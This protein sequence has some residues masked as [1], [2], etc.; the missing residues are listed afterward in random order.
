MRT[1]SPGPSFFGVFWKILSLSVLGLLALQ[2]CSVLSC[3]NRNAVTGKQ[4]DPTA[5]GT[6][7]E[8]SA[9]TAFSGGT[10]RIVVAFNDETNDGTFIT[11][12]STTRHMNVGASL[13][14]WS[15]SDDGGTT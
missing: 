4:G 10:T 14:G 8:T 13:M 5:S 1:C 2:A 15:Y 11:Y 12:T 3:S 6:Q 9:T 7:S